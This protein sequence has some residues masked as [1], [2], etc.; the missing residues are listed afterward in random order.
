MVAGVVAHGRA[1]LAAVD[2][3]HGVVDVHDSPAAIP[4]E[5]VEHLPVDTLQPRYLPAAPEAI[6]RP[7]A[8][9][10][11]GQLPQPELGRAQRAPGGSYFSSAVSI[12]RPIPRA[13]FRIRY[14]TS[15]V[16]E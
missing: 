2:R 5:R 6:Q 1:L 7:V 3:L 13:A 14:S 15:V 8:G 11:V 9:G 4:E 16:R 10:R 12:I